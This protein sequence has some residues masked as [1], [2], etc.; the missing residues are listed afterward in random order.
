MFFLS[1][2]AVRMFCLPSLVS[3]AVMGVCIAAVV[4]MCRPESADKGF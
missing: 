3:G 1:G 4:W 2:T